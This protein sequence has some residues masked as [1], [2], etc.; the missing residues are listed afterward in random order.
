M[1]HVYYGTAEYDKDRFLFDSIAAGMPSDTILLVPD[2]FTLQAERNAFE[3]MNTDT[4]LELE[5]MSNSSFSN[6]I[7]DTQ[8]R[9]AAVPVD[10]YGRYMLLA[11]L[12]LSG[13]RRTGIFAAV[14]RKRS[15]ITMLNDLIGEMKQFDVAPEDLKE[16]A[17]EFQG[18]EILHSKLMD[19]SDIFRRYEEGIAGK[20]I[21]YEDLQSVITDK[22]YESKRVAES[23]FWIDGFDYLTPKMT[24]M[25]E[26]IACTAKGVN[27][28]FTG[29][30]SGE[31]I[32]SISGRMRGFLRETALRNGIE[33]AE[34]AIPER[35]RMHVAPKVS[36][37]EASDFYA[38]AETAAIEITK[39]VR[40]KGF[41]YRD[42]VIICNDADKRGSVFRRVFGTY[43][44]PLFI[45]RKSGITHQPAV[46]FI[47]SMLAVIRNGR[48]F[49]DVFSMIKTGYSPVSDDECEELENY[50]RKYHIKSGRWKKDFVYG[51]KD[52]GEK[53]LA[54]INDC[55]RRIDE[56]ITAG[57]RLF[58]GRRTVREKT[59]ALC[60]FLAEN[61]NMPELTENAR[62]KLEAADM[63]E[64]AESTA[65]I[66]QTIVS[67][68][69]QIVEVTGDEEIS[70]EDFAEILAEGFEEIEVG[71]LPPNND[72]VIFG[73]MQRTR[74]GS[75]R[76]MFVAGANEGVLPEAGRTEG[77]L[78]D[79]EKR[80][81]A[82]R[83]HIISKTDE[84]REMEQ[85]LA[86]YKN[87]NKAREFLFVS[88]ADM[89]S[90]GAAIRPS[91][92]VSGL[93][94]WYMDAEVRQD[95]VRSGD[96]FELM[97]TRQGALPH[98]TSA[99]RERLGG[100]ALSDAWKAA[101]VLM[102]GS[103]NFEA[104]KAGLFYSNKTDRIERDTVKELYGRGIS[105]ELILSASRIERF[106]RCPFSFLV[107][108]GLRPQEERSFEVDSRSIG[109]IYH[110][111][112]RNIADVLT[113]EGVE[114]TSPASRWMTVGE[115]ECREL[116]E[117]YVDDFAQK[118]REGIFNVQG[119]GEYLRERIK[120]ICF[121]TAWLM[122]SQVRSG[123]IKAV[124]FERRF[125]RG[126]DAVFPPVRLVSDTGDDVYIEGIID[127]IDIIDGNAGGSCDYVR[128][129]DYKSGNERFDLE[130][131]KSGWRLQLMIYLKG[132][133]GGIE[134]IRPAGVF[135]FVVGE[136]NVDI[137]SVPAA[138]AEGKVAAEIAKSARLDGVLL[139]DEAVITGMDADFETSS[140]VIPVRRK[141]DGDYTG[142]AVLSD[143][144]FEELLAATDVN[145]RQ[146]A[147]LLAG[148]CA[149]IAP[150]SGKNINAC[151]LCGFKSICNIE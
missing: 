85:N 33:Y 126:A 129:I 25:I 82:D 51:V 43:G 8:G 84:L 61:V 38:E 98:L 103:R 137:T 118:Y 105:R 130:E 47:F 92:L 27:I 139:K 151:S 65:Q 18:D 10:K 135:Y 29:D 122:I 81:I 128:I 113:D 117:R 109:D 45:D 106:A 140:D 30:N 134:D 97:Q 39:L 2:Q 52:E 66:W 41:R 94:E 90:D 111:C 104:A 146:Q 28:V 149:D 11:S 63:F 131:V 13:E 80:L 73:T 74:T 40:E 99:L 124:C 48:R 58:K 55:R 34:T 138:D 50:C 22:I 88:Y 101:A 127:R 35:Y 78:S 143:E 144:E 64:Y 87:I 100:G 46:E 36:V 57:E 120:E 121:Q 59:E 32:F 132:A 110:E 89:D 68:F 93:M 70:A 76:A 83:K 31:G 54:R 91:E 150:K 42:I 116:A 115:R 23:E 44:I 107:S 79:E 125:G 136:K 141:K 145:L 148:G 60:R 123:H 4:L 72:Q 12:L 53:R 6:R 7:L 147:A 114:I 19:I 56:F 75:V 69:D 16:I 96:P 112:M 26:A 108:Y 1:V 17:R 119:R 20:Y 14:N 62:R 95:C 71:L 102:E 21:D 67:I 9:P 133:L 15:F 77:L 37:I 86:I 3:Y 5:I 142:K 49:D 24:G